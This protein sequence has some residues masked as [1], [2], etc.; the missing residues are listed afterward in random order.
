MVIFGVIGRGEI[1]G[2]GACASIA[3]PYEAL[4]GAPLLAPETAIDPV[5]VP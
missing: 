3:A 1:T 5:P 2:G 4:L